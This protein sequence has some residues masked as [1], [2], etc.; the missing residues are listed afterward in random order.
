[1]LIEDADFTV[2][3]FE[4]TGLYPY[5]GDRICEIGA[6]RFGIRSRKPHSFHRLIDPRRRISPGAFRVN[7]ITDAMVR[8]KP[9]I[10]DVL[11][12][13]LEFINGSILVAYNAPFD[14]GFLQAALDNDAVIL[15]GHHVID[16]LQLARRLF[17]GI[18]RYGLGSVADY[19]GIP[20]G[21]EHR[22]IAD[23]TMTWKVFRKEI[24]MMMRDGVKSVE[25][26]ER[27]RTI[28]SSARNITKDYRITIIEDAI[29]EQRQLSIV[30]RSE[31]NSGTTNRIIS[32]K[33][34]RLGY[35]HSYV[36]AYCHL[37][38]EE[39]TFRLDCM[40]DICVV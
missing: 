22:A 17:P 27:C 40:V 29:R 21:R 26:I 35:D 34:V 5:N 2:F 39:R 8:G 28:K 7:G 11:P 20:R 32:P 15:E 36:R 30:Y 24:A 23:A 33:E 18:G 25:D 3:D 19:L 38:K 10:G 14:L 9:V 16:A 12:D 6:L 31:W 1:M 4:T 37:R 13:F